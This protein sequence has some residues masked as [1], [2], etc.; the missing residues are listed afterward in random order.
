MS[1][2]SYNITEQDIITGKYSKEDMINLFCGCTAE[3]LN[4]YQLD[5]KIVY[6]YIIRVFMDGHLG[7]FRLSDK[8]TWCDTAKALRNIGFA[9]CAEWVEEFI[10]LSDESLC[11]QFDKKFADKYRPNAINAKIGEY[12]MKNPQ[13]FAFSGEVD[14]FGI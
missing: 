5:I 13:N 14:I 2:K 6:W 12:I 11:G 7:F 3:Q 4:P 10:A 8:E 1:L 9:D